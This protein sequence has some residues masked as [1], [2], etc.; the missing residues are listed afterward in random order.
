MVIGFRKRGLFHVVMN[1]T[2]FS[3]YALYENNQKLIVWRNNP[4][5]PS[6]FQTSFLYFLSVYEVSNL[7]G[8]HILAVSVMLRKSYALIA[9]SI[10][11]ISLFIECKDT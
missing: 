3:V 7:A 6:M 2:T 4:V 11:P 10:V 1:N 5:P 9:L 8:S